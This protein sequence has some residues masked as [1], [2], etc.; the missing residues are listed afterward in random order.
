[1]VLATEAGSA[2]DTKTFL[3]LGFARNDS[4]DALTAGS[5][6]Y[7]SAATAGKM[8]NTAPSSTDNVIQVLGWA[9]TTKLIFF[10][11]SLVQVEHV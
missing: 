11:P 7:L 8:T 5:F 3:V 9:K 2:S 1:V 6:I 10:N 4:W